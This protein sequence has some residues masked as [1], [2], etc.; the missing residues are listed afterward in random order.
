MIET[1][2][3]PVQIGNRPEVEYKETVRKV[4]FG[5]GYAQVS[6]AG[7]NGEVIS[8]PYSFRGKVE[9]AL[10]IRDFLRR[11]RKKAFIWT[12]PYGEE[13]LYLAAADSVKFAAVGKTQGIV[14]ATFEQTA[15]L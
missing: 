7:L 10:A 15:S 11:H 4:Q 5:D 12:P 2:N 13:G 8:F 1:F 9:I 3:W 6:G 14:S